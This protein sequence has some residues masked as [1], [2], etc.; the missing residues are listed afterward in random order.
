MSRSIKKSPFSRIKLEKKVDHN[1]SVGIKKPIKIFNKALTIMPAYENMTFLIYNGK[2]FVTFVVKADQV[3]M[4]FGMFCE[5]R[6]FG[7]HKEKT[8]KEKPK[9]KKTKTGKK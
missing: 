8:T 2:K 9:E 6:R 3:G 1:I 7:G 5:T 4:C